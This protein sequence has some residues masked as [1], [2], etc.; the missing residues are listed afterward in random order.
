MREEHEMQ[1]IKEKYTLFSNFFHQILPT[2]EL[3]YSLT[4]FGFDKWLFRG[5]PSGKFEL[6]PS[7]LRK[8]AGKFL[9]AE[10]GG[11]D[12]IN[13]GN[14]VRCEYYKLWQFYKIS[15]EHGLKITGSDSMK[16]EYLSSTTQAFARACL[17]TQ[18]ECTISTKS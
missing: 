18:I 12:Q 6:L 17:K 10:W 14:Q 15:N 8:D 3:G 1:V 4:E 13:A 16:S 7:A 9:N 11:D 5:E 2:G